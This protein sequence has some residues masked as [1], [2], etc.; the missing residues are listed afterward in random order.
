MSGRTE[1]SPDVSLARLSRQSQAAV[2]GVNTMLLDLERNETRK[3]AN[4][5]AAL[6]H[7]IPAIGDAFGDDDAYTLVARAALGM[8]YDVYDSHTTEADREA[9][10]AF[11]MNIIRDALEG[12]WTH[13]NRIT[14]LPRISR[15]CARPSLRSRQRKMRRTSSPT[16]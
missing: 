3:I 13:V 6:E 8:L 11:S 9:H 12:A 14:I 16:C 5:I 1:I 7:S 2:R 15:R 4:A 10:K